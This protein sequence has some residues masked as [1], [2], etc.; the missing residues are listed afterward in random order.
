[1]N[2][3]PFLLSTS[4]L[5][6]MAAAAQPAFAQ[7]TSVEASE[8][9][10]QDAAD[11]PATDGQGIPVILVTAER[12]TSDVQNTA[13]S[14]S[15]RSGEGLA[16]QGKFTTRQVLED[17]P[18]VVALENNSRNTGSSDVQGNNIT[19]RGITPGETAG[20]GFSQISPTPATAVYVDGIYEGVGSVHDLERVEV[21]RGPQGTLYGRSATAGVVA[22]HT[23]NPRVGRFE[24]NGSVEFGSYELQH[25]TGAVNVPVGSTIALRISGDYYDQGEGFFGEADR[26]MRERLNGRAKLLWEPNADLSVLLGYAYEEDNAF[27]GGTEIFANPARV[28][29]SRT[30]PIFPGHKEQNQ[31][32]AEV[33]WDL[34]PVVVTYQPAYRTWEQD[35]HNLLQGNFLGSG[36]PIQ[37]FINTPENSFHT[38]ELRIA[39]D[40]N[41]ALSWLVGAFYYENE[42]DTSLRNFLADANNNEIALQSQ[43]SDQ[44]NTRDF[45]LFAEATYSVTPDL[46]LTLG[47][48]YDDTKIIFSETAYENPYSLCGTILQ[49]ALPPFIGMTCTGP[50]Q[51][52]GPPGPSLTV[53]DLPIKDENFNYKARVEYD[54]S[55]S[56]MLY[57]LVSTGFRPG[58]GG[59]N[60]VINPPPVGPALV[61]NIYGAE[62][63]TSFEIG[64][65][66]RFLD[67]N[68]QINAAA[69]YY[70]YS[71]Y[72]TSFIPN[73]A[74]PFDP[75]V[76]GT[77]QRTTVP[78][79][80]TGAELE[81]AYRPSDHDQ[82]TFNYSY[83]HF[84]WKDKPAAFAGAQTEDGRAVVPH[85]AQ[86]SYHHTFDL[87]G[88]HTLQA[89]IDGEFQSAHRTQDLHI[90]W[91][92]IGYGQYVH[93]GDRLV[94]N[95][96]LTF[97]TRD[98]RYSLTGYVRNFTDAG[99]PTLVVQ[100][101][102]SEMRVDYID[103]RVFGIRA[104]VQF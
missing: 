2:R 61:L 6:C 7:D 101:D 3:I 76:P 70:D 58:D 47:A 88:G 63:L 48:R 45:G 59:I 42:L 26:G 53:S 30:S 37:Q 51:S 98:G 72:H 12:R 40:W 21:L 1:M 18:G 64:S 10:A 28:I 29:G 80:V 43:T 49:G 84:R 94:G 75:A 33:N 89:G 71:G 91:L 83:V 87:Q 86:A 31:Y 41:S 23:R 44:K 5:G 11:Q 99:H 81:L 68:L 79:R 78:A 24:A 14:V 27:S 16:E 57:A 103:P 62:K 104:A 15:V 69:F 97:L 19:I 56:N 60:R 9:G 93:V 38:Q 46:R 66:N 100:G 20:P 74:N 95:A 17:I 102:P 22:F 34:G 39:S 85:T 65:K 73:T 77:L 32:W 92:T 90:D 54:L 96:Q 55:D 50:G 35:D 4:M 82:F 67:N 52:S 36:V 25:Y 13:A 8:K